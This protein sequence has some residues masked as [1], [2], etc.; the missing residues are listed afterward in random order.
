A[1]PGNIPWGILIV[2]L[3]DF[4]RNDLGMPTAIALA[5]ISLVAFCSF[6]GNLCGGFFGE[7]FYKWDRRYLC[8]FCAAANILRIIPFIFIFG[9]S[10]SA[11]SGNVQFSFLIFLMLGGFLATLP[12]PNMGAIILNV[13][14]PEVRCTI[15]GLF[16]VLDDLSKAVGG[17][18]VSLLFSQFGS[19]KTSFQAI[20]G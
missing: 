16:T 18:L 13:N 10:S 12:T 9:Y 19:R 6:C 8:L 15:F 20:M 5:Q 1:F 17:F 7:A 2:Y 11:Q 14:P 3:H 4:L